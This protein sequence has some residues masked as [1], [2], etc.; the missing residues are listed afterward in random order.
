MVRTTAIHQRSR[1]R[2]RQN[3]KATHAVASAFLTTGAKSHLIRVWGWDWRFL[4]CC[5]EICCQEI[6]CQAV[7]VVARRSVVRP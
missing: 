4:T 5:Q 2:E 3:L 1:P 6:C 7:I